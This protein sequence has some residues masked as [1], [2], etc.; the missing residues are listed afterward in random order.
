LYH[1]AILPSA[2]AAIS[3]SMFFFIGPGICVTCF[4][5]L[6]ISLLRP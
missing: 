3:L 4:A 6:N 5:Q 1:F 2:F